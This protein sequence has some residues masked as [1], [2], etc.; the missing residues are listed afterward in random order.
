MQITNT[1]TLTPVGGSQGVLSKA[2][3]A[4]FTVTGCNVLPTVTLSNIQT[5]A[6]VTWAWTMQKTATPNVYQI[7]V[8]GGA[9]A[10][11]RVQLT[12]TYST[13]NFWMSGTLRWVWVFWCG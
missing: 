1:A 5:W 2:A 12:R 3:S 7:P 13:G 8:G 4:T 9:T 6:A 10:N 11:Y